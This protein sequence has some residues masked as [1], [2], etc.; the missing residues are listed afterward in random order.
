MALN[1]HAPPI[2]AIMIC[3]ALGVYA[4]IFVQVSDL[5]LVDS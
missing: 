5:R 4:Y 1:I 3:E 2:F